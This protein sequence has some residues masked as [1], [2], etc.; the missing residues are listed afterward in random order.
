MQCR[1]TTRRGDRCQRSAV[2]GGVGFC[3][4]H[5]PVDSASKR[6][7]WKQRI[8][9][10][11]LVVSSAELI[12]KIAELAAEHLH[13][14]FG[15]GDPDQ[16]N[17]KGRLQEL[18]FDEP[19]FPS[20][21]ESY[22]PGSRVD[23]IALEEFVREAVWLRDHSDNIEP[24]ALPWLEGKFSAWFDQMNSYHRSVLLGQIEKL[25][26][27]ANGDGESASCGEQDVP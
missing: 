17:A 26:T 23:W 18:L 3:W 10:A 21:P 9:A 25:C 12:I 13:E 24:A 11:A 5:V 15:A 16:N 4:Q 2:E 14:F 7:R 1:M 20:F 27:S 6:E 22:V 19:P 8:E